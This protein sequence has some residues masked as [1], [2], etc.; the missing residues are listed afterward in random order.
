MPS[1]DGTDRRCEVKVCWSGMRRCKCQIDQIDGSTD[2]GFEAIGLLVNIHR[3]EVD[4][5]RN[6]KVEVDRPSVL[7]TRLTRMNQ[8]VSLMLT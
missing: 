3:I 1:C 4:L 5:P 2:V 6:A 8:V 7:H